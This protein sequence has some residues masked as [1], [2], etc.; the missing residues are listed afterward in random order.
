M[1]SCSECGEHVTRDY[2][3]V[4]GVD[5]AVH[6][7]PTCSTYRDLHGGTGGDQPTK[8]AQQSARP[9]YPAQ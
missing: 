9:R 1:P 5:G 8:S 6:G 3:R 4:F 7:C 2:V